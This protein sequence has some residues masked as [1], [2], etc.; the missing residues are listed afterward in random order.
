[1]GCPQRVDIGKV[2]IVVV[3]VGEDEVENLGGDAVRCGVIA[4]IELRKV[5]VEIHTTGWWHVSTQASVTR[6]GVSGY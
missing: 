6:S 4:R 3:T 1:M 2:L 5:I